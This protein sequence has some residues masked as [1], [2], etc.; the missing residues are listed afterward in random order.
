MVRRSP[1]TL[2]DTGRG[3]ATERLEPQGGLGL[4]RWLL[5]QPMLHHLPTSR[6]V[7]EESH[8]EGIDRALTTEPLPV[9]DR[10]TMT[11]A[12][13]AAMRIMTGRITV[14]GISRWTRPWRSYCMV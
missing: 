8:W 10:P 1:A 13:H 12:Y 9:Q 6:P 4:Q 2:Q 7:S 5:G 3:E 11:Y 14:L